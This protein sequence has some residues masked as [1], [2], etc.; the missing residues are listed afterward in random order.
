M[1][2]VSGD[3]Q[4]SCNNCDKTNA[5]RYCKECSMFFCP[6][7]LYHHNMFKPNAGH[8]ILSLD[9]VASTAYQLPQ[10][11]LEATGNCTDHNKPLEIFCETCEELICQLCTVNCVHAGHS[12]DV[13]SDTYKKHCDTIMTSSLQP[14]NKEIE[15][16]TDAIA[17]LFNRREEVKQQGETTKKEIHVTIDELKSVLD[18]TERKLTRE[19]DVAVQHKVSVLDH[20]IKEVETALG[21]VRECRDHVEQCLKIGT[22]Q[23]VI[24][25]TKSR[26]ICCSKSVINSVKDKTFQPLEQADIELVKSNKINEI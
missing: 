21:Q 26:M 14:L 15:Q 20:Q 23:Q 11:K 12:H 13:V 24:I 8:Q 16:L 1:K 7:C 17:K 4:A 9:E 18:E 25:S 3:Q 5:N 19:V 22:R 6:E 10:A 2:K